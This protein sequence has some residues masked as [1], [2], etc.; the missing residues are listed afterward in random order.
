MADDHAILEIKAKVDD[1][2]AQVKRVQDQVDKLDSE[3]KTAEGPATLSKGMDGL[4]TAV[5]GLAAGLAAL[6]VADFFRGAVEQAAEA[7]DALSQV[8]SLIAS[9]G[10][11]AKRTSEDLQ[12]TAASLAALSAYDDDEILAGTTATLLRIGSNGK[13]AGETFD[14]TQVAA[15]NLAARMRTDL[16]PAADLLGKALIAPGEGLRSLKTAGVE[17]SDGQVKTLQ[18]W[19]ETGRLADAQAVI[20]ARVEKA[21]DGAATAYRDT[22]AGSLQ[23]VKREFGEVQQAFG[24]GFADEIKSDAGEAAD[25]LRGLRPAAEDAGRAVGALLDVGSKVLSFWPL[26]KAASATSIGAMLTGISKVQDVALRAID[27][28]VVGL[29]KLAS[30]GTEIPLLGKLYE[31]AVATAGKVRKVIAGLREGIV[32]EVRN[33]GEGY[34]EVAKEQTQ[35]FTDLWVG[36]SD[37]VLSVKGAAEQSTPSLTV[38]GD[39]GKKAGEKI[40]EGVKLATQATEELLVTRSRLPSLGDESGGGGDAARVVA[41]LKAKQQQAP[42]TTE[43]ML[44][45]QE[46]ED[47]LASSAENMADKLRPAGQIILAA[48]QDASRAAPELKKV[49]ESAQEIVSPLGQAAAAAQEARAGMEGAAEGA[50][51]AAMTTGDY[52]KR[53]EEAAAAA[54]KAGQ[55]AGEHK[56]S[57]ENLALGLEGLRDRQEANNRAAAAGA[58]ASAAQATAVGQTADAAQQAASALARLKEENPVGWIQAQRDAWREV[59]AEI[60]WINGTEGLGES[61]RLARELASVLAGAE[62]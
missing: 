61:V 10:G 58:E 55:A 43:E 29:Q 39:E 26:L 25:S 3:M 47:Q 37:A 35:K 24:E 62:T 30:L 8:E 21:V 12:G 50:T 56:V 6:K 27:S 48:G 54:L 13:L 18:T 42:L 4:K 7:E 41:E 60:A 57:A 52:G 59:R 2:V 34:L 31:G 11:A 33:M 16:A 32:T 49:A 46:A 9:T 36:A 51:Q 53:A 19:A 22:L 20:L 44:R 17:F 23:V 5:A 45:L 15:V 14:R 28:L 1:A 38:L 40:A